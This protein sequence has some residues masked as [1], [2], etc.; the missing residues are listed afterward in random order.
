MIVDSSALVAVVL[1]EPTADAILEVLVRESRVRVSAADLLETWM[2]ID[3]RET[4]ESAQIL[5]GLLARIDLGVE[6]VTLTQVEIARNAFRLYGKGSG[7]GAR[8]NFGDCF[9]YALAKE[10]SEPL[11]FVGNDFG[12]TDI[13]PAI[14]QGDL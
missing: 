9:A 7:H 1:D 8:L 2:V 6:P 12:Q 4:A 11:L 10:R 3:R 13:V 14:T 5:A